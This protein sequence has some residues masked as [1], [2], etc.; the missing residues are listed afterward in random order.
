MGVANCAAVRKIKTTK[1]NSG[2]F[3]RNKNILKNYPPYS[4][5]FF[6]W[7]A[8]QLPYGH[9]DAENGSV[10]TFAWVSAQDTMH[11]EGPMT[12]HVLGRIC[13]LN[14]SLWMAVCLCC[15]FS[16][17]LPGIHVRKFD[18]MHVIS[19]SFCIRWKDRRTWARGYLHVDDCY[20]YTTHYSLGELVLLLLC[21]IAFNYHIARSLEVQV[22]TKSI[23]GEPPLPSLNEALPSTCIKTVA[24][25]Q[26]VA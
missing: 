3:S 11:S 24:I 15:H 10:S 5:F 23:K 12:Y 21:C 20:R 6:L 1:I 8:N 25:Q 17:I 26:R 4:M 13:G 14:H 22:G 18:F 2:A 9:N 16:I 7:L 19:S